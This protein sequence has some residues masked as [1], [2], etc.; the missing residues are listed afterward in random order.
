MHKGGPTYFAPVMR[1]EV[2]FAHWAHGH[3]GPYRTHGPHGPHIWRPGPKINLG[4]STSLHMGCYRF[5]IM[6]NN[7]Q[8]NFDAKSILD[9]FKEVSGLL[10][11]MLQ[12]KCYTRL[13]KVFAPSRFWVFT[14]GVF[15][16]PVGRLFL[17]ARA[18]RWESSVISGPRAL[19][20]LYLK[21]YGEHWGHLDKG[22]FIGFRNY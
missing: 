9:E 22:G 16:A 8:L 3:Y 2:S 17:A 4:L 20:I 21:M 18:C 6:C 14:S 11:T 1:R 13:H 5:H 15:A 7:H 19:A 10:W 12:S